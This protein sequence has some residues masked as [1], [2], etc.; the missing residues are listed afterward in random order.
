MQTLDSPLPSPRTIL[1]TGGAG[2]IGSHTCV[3]LLT[4][5]YDV[6]VLDNHSNSSPLALDRVAALSGVG[7]SAAYVGDV[8]DSALLAGIFAAHPIDAV[9]HFAAKKAVAES[10]GIPLEYYDINVNGTV[11]LMLAMRAAGVNQLVFS[12]SCS[13]Y[14]AGQDV[15]ITEDDPFAPT[16]PYA[17][18]KLMCEQML[19]DA[20]ARYPEL[21]VI[22]LRYFNPVGA[23]ASG[24]LGEDPT[25]VP[26]NVMPYMAQVAVGRRE[27]LTVFGNDYATVDGTGVRDYIHVVDVADG[28]RVAL[29]HLLDEDG[30]SAFNLGTGVGTSVLQ[31][32]EAFGRASGQRIPITF[33]RRRPGDVATLIADPGRVAAAWG[34]KT[35]RDVNQMCRDAWAFQERNPQGYASLVENLPAA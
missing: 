22:A 5:G 3:E 2:F 14:G 8:R 15:P 12:S 4:H 17:R 16:N 9:I 6:V 34:W 32:A 35:T 27:E 25:G 29:Q 24:L 7:V 11:Q 33:A 31:L 18:S 26:N 28:H 20:C 10:V 23:H 1:V 30:M 13:L 19:A 21:R